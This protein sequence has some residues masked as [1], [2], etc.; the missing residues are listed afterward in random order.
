MNKLP[1]IKLE[2]ETDIRVRFNEVDALH[3]VWHGHYVNY[4]EDGRQ[5]FGQKFKL[6][7]LDVF[8]EGFTTPIVEFNCF[9]KAPLVFGDVARVKTTYVDSPAAKIIFDYQITKDNNVLVAKG[10]SV[11][12]FLNAKSRKLELYKPQFFIDW[13]KNNGLSG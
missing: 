1:D 3:I 10:R 2:C 13:K 11:Q 8:N 4:F 12:V 6:G 5:A 9:H 7:Y